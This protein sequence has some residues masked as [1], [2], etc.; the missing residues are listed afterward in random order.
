MVHKK[1][2]SVPAMT[3]DHKKIRYYWANEHVTWPLDDWK[4]VIFSDEKKFNLDSLDGFAHYFHDLR[5]EL[6]YFYTHQ[7]GGQS[8]MVQGA[9]AYDGTSSS[10][11]INEK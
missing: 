4:E 9:I 3:E 11:F 6:R 1:V 2:K 7:Q 10:I 5:T 8:F